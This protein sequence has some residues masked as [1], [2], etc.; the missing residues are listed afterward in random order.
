[1]AVRGRTSTEPRSWPN[2]NHE[3]V[4]RG[5]VAIR[6]ERED[7]ELGG[8]KRKQS[9]KLTTGTSG[10]EAE[11]M[12]RCLHIGRQADDATGTGRAAIHTSQG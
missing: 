2:C 10:T 5:G 7:Q 3:E 1:M 12:D 11:S 9:S 8:R 6:G 4:N